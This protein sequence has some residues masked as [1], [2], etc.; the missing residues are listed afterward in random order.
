VAEAL[1]ELTEHPRDGVVQLGQW[2]R[3]RGTIAGW[4]I[5][6][7]LRWT[8]RSIFNYLR[9]Y[10]SCRNTW[11]WHSARRNRWRTR[12]GLTS[13]LDIGGTFPATELIHHRRITRTDVH[14]R[15]PRCPQ[16]RQW[17]VRLRRHAINWR[18]AGHGRA[19]RID[20][21]RHKGQS[22][23]VAFA[24]DL[25][26]TSALLTTAQAVR[27]VGHVSQASEADVPVLGFSPRWFN[28]AGHELPHV[29]GRDLLKA[30][31]LDRFV[32]ATKIALGQ[33]CKVRRCS[34]G[35]DTRRDRQAG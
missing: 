22:K 32:L 21:G 8:I 12:T 30:G 34:G 14:P 27:G 23:H 17:L 33:A 29:D 28:L 26:Q 18:R 24:S 10:K 5:S 7:L 11:M 25:V 3:G 35:R 15:S 19:G 16:T 31:P 13:I 9:S 20:K 2:R 4:T 1:A 6:E